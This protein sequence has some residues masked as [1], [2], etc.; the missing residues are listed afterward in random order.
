MS[1]RLA[2]MAA[3][4]LEVSSTT[5]F[6]YL[7][8]SFSSSVTFAFTMAMDSFIFGTWSFR[9]RMFCSRMSSGSSAAEIIQPNIERK[10]R[11]MRCH[12]GESSSEAGLKPQLAMNG[13][14]IHGCVEPGAIFPDWGPRPLEVQIGPGR[15]G[16]PLH[17]P[18][19]PPGVEVVLIETRPGGCELLRRRAGERRAWKVQ[20]A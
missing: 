19:P 11:F 8:F 7:R 17:H 1:S 3:F 18:S 10:T 5:S 6:L 20:V 9:S 12:M 15:G 16:F 14:M 4:T 2:W 13:N